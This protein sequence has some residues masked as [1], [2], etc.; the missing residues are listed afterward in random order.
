M[1]ENKEKTFSYSYSAKDRKEVEDIRKKY[2][3]QPQKQESALERLRRLD[4]GVTQKATVVALILGIVGVLILGTG[5]SFIM[6]DIGNALG[7]LAIV[8][9]VVLGGVGIIVCAVSYPV[10]MAITVKEKKKI[11]PEILQLTEELLK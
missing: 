2:E 1:E 10:Y 6:T 8:L 11:A 3:E 9:G 4:N 5:M 7:D